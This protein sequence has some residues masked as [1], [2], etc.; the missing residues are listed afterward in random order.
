MTCSLLGL[1]GSTKEKDPKDPKDL[2]SLILRFVSLFKKLDRENIESGNRPNKVLRV[3]LVL[4][5]PGSL[6]V[7]SRSFSVADTSVDSASWPTAVHG[8]H[9]SGGI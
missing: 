4:L 1:D 6:I 5:A 2:D 3:L 8:E 7:T 9:A